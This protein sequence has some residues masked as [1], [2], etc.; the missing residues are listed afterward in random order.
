MTLSLW[1]TDSLLAD[2]SFGTALTSGRAGRGVAGPPAALAA[3][4][5]GAYAGYLLERTR[6]RPAGP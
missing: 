3:V 4:A 2:R 6:R 5:L 1:S